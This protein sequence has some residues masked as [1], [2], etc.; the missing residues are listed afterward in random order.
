MRRELRVCE[1]VR[2]RVVGGVRVCGRVQCANTLR[3]PTA[4]CRLASM[5]LRMT[6]SRSRLALVNI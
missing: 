3:R 6:R 2:P 1:C 5:R 4:A